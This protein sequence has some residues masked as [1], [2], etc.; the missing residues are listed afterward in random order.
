MDSAGEMMVMNPDGGAIAMLTTTRVV[1][2]GSNQ[3]LNR[4]FYDVALFDTAATA[5]RLGDIARATKMTPK[6]Q[7][8]RISEILRF[9][10]M[11]P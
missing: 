8:V 2:S 4:A 1:F 9:W 7:T 5:M 10:A 6:F 3:Q 11:S